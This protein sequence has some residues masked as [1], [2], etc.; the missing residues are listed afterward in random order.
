MKG[1]TYEDRAR[2]SKGEASNLE[3]LEKV[4]AMKITADELEKF[5]SEGGKR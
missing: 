4:D 1:L 3:A 5:Q 2:V